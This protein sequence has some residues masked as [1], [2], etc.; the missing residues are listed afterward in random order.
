VGKKGRKLHNGELHDLHPWPNII[1][2]IK[3]RRMWWARH[4]ARMGKWECMQNFNRKTWRE[5]TNWETQAY[6][7]RYSQNGF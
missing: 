5:K 4:V 2:V 7:R 3:S 1:M 6:M